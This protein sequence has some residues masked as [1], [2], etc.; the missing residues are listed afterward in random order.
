MI[1][2]TQQTTTTES[3]ERIVVHFGKCVGVKQVRTVCGYGA[4]VRTTE[5]GRGHVWTSR[6]RWV[7][8]V[9]CAKGLTDDRSKPCGSG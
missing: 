4:G 6:L 5:W 9:H 2:T 7:T 8:C 1:D 3:N